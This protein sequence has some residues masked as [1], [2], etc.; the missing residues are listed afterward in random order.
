MNGI[1]ALSTHAKI[2][3]LSVI[4]FA[5]LVRFGRKIQFVSNKLYKTLKAFVWIDRWRITL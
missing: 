3:V 4:R 1:F 2:L 5:I